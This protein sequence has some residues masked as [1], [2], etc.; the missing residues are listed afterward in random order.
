M[1][2]LVFIATLAKKA[3]DSLAALVDGILRRI[4]GKKTQVSTLQKHNRLFKTAADRL[5]YAVRDVTGEMLEI[6]NGSARLFV[7]STNFSFESLTAYW[8]C[9]NKHV[10]GDLLTRASLPVP[11]NALVSARDYRRAIGAFQAMDKPVVVKPVRGACGRGVTVNISSARDFRRA[12]VNT[13]RF[14][15]EILIERFV[16][17]NHWRVTV[18]DGDLIVSWQRIS[19]FVVGDGDKDVRGLIRSYN[20]TLLDTGDSAIGLPIPVD[21]RAR[22]DLL[23][24]GYSLDTVPLKGEKITVILACNSALGGRTRDV[25]D[26]IHPGYVDV[27]VKAARA[28]GAR[29]AGID[30]IADDITIAPSP[31]EFF[32][33]EVNT[34]P[35]MLSP[36]YA[37]QRSRS[38]VDYAEV[39]LRKSLAVTLEK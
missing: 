18:L 36:D 26:D 34:T 8:I 7:T 39:V 32:I 10:S 1:R 30:I 3:K 12:F 2:L 22:R 25:T 17:G 28:V 15:N 20:T 9:G 5:G 4:F 11:E 37:L 16:T 27:A 29:F 19:A 13:A 35:D 6:S 21:R 33:N 24:Q 23:S 38:A 31:G 14:C